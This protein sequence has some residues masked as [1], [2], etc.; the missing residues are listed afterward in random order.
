LKV[1]LKATLLETRPV[2]IKEG[3]SRARVAASAVKAKN[4]LET[5]KIKILSRDALLIDVPPFSD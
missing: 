4:K 1:I 2:G 3:F 5:S